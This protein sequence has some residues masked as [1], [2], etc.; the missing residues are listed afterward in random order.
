MAI[1]L[2]RKLSNFQRADSIQYDYF[3]SR[4]QAPSAFVYYLDWFFN[5][6]LTNSLNSG[7]GRVGRDANSGWN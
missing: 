4:L 5:D 1:F 7:C 3:T 2:Y 6:A